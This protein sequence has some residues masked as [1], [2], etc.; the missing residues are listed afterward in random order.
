MAQHHTGERFHVLLSVERWCAKKIVAPKRKWQ[1]FAA[2]RAPRSSVVVMPLN[3]RRG[4]ECAG[5]RK[6]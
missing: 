4:A 2:Q 3:A 1:Q 6:W 5:L